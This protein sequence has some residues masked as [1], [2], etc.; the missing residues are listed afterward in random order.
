MLSEAR[1]LYLRAVLKG[2][3]V[4]LKGYTVVLKSRTVV[5]KGRSVVFKGLRDRTAEMMVVIFGA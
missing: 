1:P 3:S 4:V 2:R 5:L